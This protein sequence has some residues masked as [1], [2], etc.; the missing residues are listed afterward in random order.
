MGG[1]WVVPI[2]PAA[3]AVAGSTSVD[4]LP[5]RSSALCT[6]CTGPAR[7]ADGGIWRVAFSAG[8]VLLR[9]A[10]NDEPLSASG[11][12]DRAVGPC[13]T[14]VEAVGGATRATALV[15]ASIGVEG[16][17]TNASFA[18]EVWFCAALFWTFS[19]TRACVLGA[20]SRGPVESHHSAG[21]PINPA[22]AA[23]QKT[24]PRRF[25]RDRWISRSISFQCSS[26]NTNSRSAIFC[27]VASSNGCGSVIGAVFWF[28][29]ELRPFP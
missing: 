19:G 10:A 6:S 3:P 29:P 1:G 8:G 12:V 7:S 5:W 24:K 26:W 22:D 13:G 23:N 14:G 21:K 27:R 28:R 4:G 15:G 16:T 25:R 18:C 11:V 20:L 17:A 9:V 2:V